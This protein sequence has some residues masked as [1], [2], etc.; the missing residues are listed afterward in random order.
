MNET[1][2]KSSTSNRGR[3]RE[4]GVEI[5]R[6]RLSLDPHDRNVVSR[7]QAQTGLLTP[8][9]LGD[10]STRKQLLLHNVSLQ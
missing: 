2:L 8:Y 1:K 3:Q 9:T 10:Q 5:P 4:Y 6:T 7:D